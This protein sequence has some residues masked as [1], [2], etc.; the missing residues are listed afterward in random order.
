MTR[1]EGNDMKA[2]RTMA[3]IAEA[4]DGRSVTWMEPV[5]GD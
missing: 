4:L 1:T 5:S 2:F 3:L